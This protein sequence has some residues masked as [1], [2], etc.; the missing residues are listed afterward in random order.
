MAR[1]ARPVAAAEGIEPIVDRAIA[2]ALERLGSDRYASRCLS[3]VEDAYE[4]AND[5]EVFGGSSARESA[6]VYGVSPS[7]GQPPAG[8]FVFYGTWGPIDGV[9]RDWGHVG[10][11][12]ADGRLI[13]AWPE[14]RIDDLNAVPALESGDW[15]ELSYL[16]WASPAQ[17]LSGAR[18]GRPS[19]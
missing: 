5:I 9:V 7:A 6:D 16:G 18:F 4:Q 1:A 12:T 10:L 3:F 13:H 2:W 19:R 14:V 17:I 11:A 8:A 15:S